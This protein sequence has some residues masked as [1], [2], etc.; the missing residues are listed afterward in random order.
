MALSNT[1]CTWHRPSRSHTVSLSG[2]MIRMAAGPRGHCSA[3]C[4]GES[5]YSVVYHSLIS[6]LPLG[7]ASVILHILVYFIMKRQKLS[8]VTLLITFFLLFQNMVSSSIVLKSRL[9]RRK[10]RGRGASTLFFFWLYPPFQPL[11]KNFGASIQT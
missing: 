2:C 3:P 8:A 4:R 11:N 6:S 1:L 7:T 9:I 5:S 10:M